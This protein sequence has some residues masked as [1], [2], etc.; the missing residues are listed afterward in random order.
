MTSV[1]FKTV[2][3]GPEMAAL[4]EGRL[5]VT[6]AAANAAHE[7]VI[8]GLLAPRFSCD[9]FDSILTPIDEAD[10]QDQDEDEADEP[11]AAG[12]TAARV[13]DDILPVGYDMEDETPMINPGKAITNA[14]GLAWMYMDKTGL[15]KY[16]V[17]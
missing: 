10:D 1:D 6:I 16:H 7:N 15:V 13:D 8:S 4:G 11:V 17:K 14:R 5:S 2:F 12:L 9:L 3:D